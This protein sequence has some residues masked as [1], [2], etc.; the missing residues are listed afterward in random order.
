MGINQ[1]LSQLMQTIKQ[2]K[3]DSSNLSPRQ[4][5]DTLESVA[6]KS[7]INEVALFRACQLASNEDDQKAAQLFDD[8]VREATVSVRKLYYDSI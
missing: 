6:L 2:M 1:N 7:A 4:F 3:S 8:L 5:A